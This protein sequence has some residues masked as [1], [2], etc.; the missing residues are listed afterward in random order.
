MMAESTVL[1]SPAA[2]AKTRHQESAARK[3]GLI[4][5]ALADPKYRAMNKAAVT[6]TAL[7]FQQAGPKSTPEGL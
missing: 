6:V 5:S 4:T 2:S 3:R 1:D 7:T